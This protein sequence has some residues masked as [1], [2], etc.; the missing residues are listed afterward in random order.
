MLAIGLEHL[1][2]RGSVAVRRCHGNQKDALQCAHAQARTS[3]R[4]A[5]SK[6]DGKNK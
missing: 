3:S 6:T 1:S 2:L 4:R 5:L